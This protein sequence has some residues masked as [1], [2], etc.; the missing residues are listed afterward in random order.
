MILQLTFKCDYPD[1]EKTLWIEVGKA[2]IQDFGWVEEYY[3]FVGKTHLCS[4]HRNHTW[5]ELK[6]QVNV[7]NV[8]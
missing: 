5:A 6:K 1:C 4:K 8:T 7:N 2:T 3:P